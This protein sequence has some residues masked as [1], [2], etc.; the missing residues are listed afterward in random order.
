MLAGLADGVLSNPEFK[1][2]SLHMGKSLRAA[3][4]HQRAVDEIFRFK[5]RT[6][7]SRRS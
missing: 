1:F 3:G 6:G 7:I 2:N 5:E 4:G